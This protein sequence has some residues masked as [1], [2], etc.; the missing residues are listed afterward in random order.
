MAENKNGETSTG[1]TSFIV[2]WALCGCHCFNDTFQSVIPA[3]FPLLKSGLG[4]SFFWV[5]LISTV[6]QFSSSIFQPLVGWYCDK[7]PMPYALPA[8]MC[9]TFIG[10]VLL[11]QAWN[12]PLI[13][14][15]VVFI[16][17]GSAVT[18]PEATRLA[19]FASGGRLGFAQSV[20]QVGGNAGSALGPLLV[21]FVVYKFG[22]GEQRS[23]IW[24]AL[25][26][27]AAILWTL[28]LCKWYIRKL[29][30]QKKEH[31]NRKS[32][33]EKT[34]A[35]P[36]LPDS[37][38]IFT[39]FILLTLVFS[40]NLYTVSLG[41]FLTFYLMDKYGIPEQSS[42]WYLFAFLF[43][44]AAGTLIGGPIGDKYGRRRIIWFS[45]LGAAP[46]TLIMPLVNS[47][48]ATCV[49]SM[50]AGAIMSSAFPAIIIYAQELMPGKV[51]TVGGLFF[52]FS[53]GA[54]AIASSLLGILADYQSI[55]YVYDVCAYLPLIGLITWFLPTVKPKN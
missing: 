23:I 18:H 2:L 7:H 6:F 4:L 41:N 45:I 13:L 15:S 5:G 31:E 53:F 3:I 27:A 51:G 37:T 34:T 52:G 38:V 20:F 29:K 17:F 30:E 8:G 12:F 10:I 49:L 16:G 32:K 40:K 19:Y 42:Q 9:S 47:L 55:G 28:P 43:S 54:G 25:L 14:I 21:L 39:I 46:F 35:G 22:G 48:W 24:F 1:R 33:K 11:S 36:N 26:S 44:A 50:A